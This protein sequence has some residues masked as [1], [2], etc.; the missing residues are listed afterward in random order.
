MRVLVTAVALAL[1]LAACSK[2]TQENYA[3]IQD[4]M[5]EQEVLVL[6]GPAT[7]SGG[8]SVLGVSG[9]S[10]KWVAGGAV[11]SIQFVNGK[12]VGKSFRRE[13]PK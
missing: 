5:S 1:L 3:K 4:G 6:L 12:V 10:S 8:L 9:G 7:E 13:P 2:V 11:I